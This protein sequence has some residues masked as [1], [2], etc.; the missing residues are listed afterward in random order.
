MGKTKAYL[1]LS[2][3]I[4]FT[5]YIFGRSLDALWAQDISDVL[6]NIANLIT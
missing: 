4:L 5:A 3:Y 1:L 6:R 2:M